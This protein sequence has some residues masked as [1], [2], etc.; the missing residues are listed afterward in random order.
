MAKELSYICRKILLFAVMVVG[1]IGYGAMMGFARETLI[2][3]WIPIFISAAM[4]LISGILLWKLWRNVTRSS[5]FWINYLLHV[6]WLTGILSGLFFSLNFLCADDTSLH[7]ETV[8]VEKKYY[9]VRHKTKRISRR[10]YGQGD[11]YNVYY[12]SIRFDDGKTKDITL[13]FDR[14]RRLKAGTQKEFPVADGLF[15]IK[16]LKRNGR[17]IDVPESH[18]Y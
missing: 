14:Y 18:H 1:A 8:V 3:I 5:K 13:P 2:D 4:A 10:V 16:I 6:V 17:K 7:E 11:A 9:K 15:G 12:I